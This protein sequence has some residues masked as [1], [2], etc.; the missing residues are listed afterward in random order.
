MRGRSRA[1]ATSAIRA[2]LSNQ[3]PGIESAAV[4]EKAPIIVV[5]APP[6]AG[7]T[8]V[9]DA[10]PR[11]NSLAVHSVADRFCAPQE[12]KRRPSPIWC[13]ERLPRLP[14]NELSTVGVIRIWWTKNR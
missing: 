10:L 12:Q 13:Y 6:G 8:S 7:K 3:V 5:T 2:P 1:R 9:D 14:F 4:H 11:S